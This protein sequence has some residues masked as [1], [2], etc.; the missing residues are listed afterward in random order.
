MTVELPP[1]PATRLPT[2]DEMV[3][4]LRHL[5]S[6][7]KLLPR[8]KRLLTDANS[9]MGEIVTLI[10]LD[11]G[12]AARVLQVGNSA[13]YS[14]G[15]RCFTID[16]AV[17]RVGYDQVYDLVSYS[18]ASQ[19]LVRPLTTYGIDADDLWKMSVACALSAELL[20]ERTGQDRDAAYTAGLLHGIGMV[21]IDDWALRNQPQ[22]RLQTT[23]FPLEAV[24]DERAVLGFTQADA[25]AALLRLWEFPNSMCEP[26]QWQ[27]APR[28]SAAHTRM[29]CLLHCA[30]WLRNQVC[31][32]AS[33][34]PQPAEFVMQMVP[35][36]PNEL[37]QLVEQVDHRLAQVSSLVEIGQ[38]PGPRVC[39]RFPALQ[40]AWSPRR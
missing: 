10:R 8:L 23:G 11:P 38:N 36:R 27:Y 37:L 25:G 20:A 19:V 6:A 30:K 39:A 40:A 3:R 16:E 32:S 1:P 9:S 33:E 29:A 7:P 12:I 34:R 26:V 13:Y 35:L 21:V 14:Q 24:K 28:S 4:D 18:V 2:A 22:L 31:L 17:N 5:P 15:V